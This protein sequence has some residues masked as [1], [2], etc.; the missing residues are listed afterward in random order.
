MKRLFL[1][2]RNDV[3][4]LRKNPLKNILRSKKAYS[5]KISQSIIYVKEY[6]YM[7]FSILKQIT[8][9]AKTL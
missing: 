1:K 3:R 5:L 6:F 8:E 9:L 7:F 4:Q 2:V